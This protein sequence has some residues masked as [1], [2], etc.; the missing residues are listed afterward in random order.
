MIATHDSCSILPCG[1]YAT[2]PLFDNPSSKRLKG[3]EKGV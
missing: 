2:A 1:K 3:M